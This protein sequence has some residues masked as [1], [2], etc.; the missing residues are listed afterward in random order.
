M[1]SR[2]LTTAVKVDDKKSL[3]R[4]RERNNISYLLKD[5]DLS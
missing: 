5:N 3:E 2:G 4:N 1:M